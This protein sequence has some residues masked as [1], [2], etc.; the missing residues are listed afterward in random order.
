MMVL[1]IKMAFAV[2]LYSKNIVE[3][4]GN[5]ALFFSKLWLDFVPGSE[6]D[7]RLQNFCY[8]THKTDSSVLATKCCFQSFQKFYK[9]WLAKVR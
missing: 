3:G 1:R 5:I 7:Y 9:Y 2:P 4:N 8:V 6:Y